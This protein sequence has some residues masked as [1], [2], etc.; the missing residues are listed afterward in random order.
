MNEVTLLRFSNEDDAALPQV[1]PGQLAQLCEHLSGIYNLAGS[2]IGVRTKLTW[3]F[4]L[5]PRKGSLEFVLIHVLDDAVV[6]NVTQI[7]RRAL[8]MSPEAAL[9]LNN[10]GLASLIYTII[11][12]GRGLVDLFVRNE[13]PVLE[14]STP[15]K[16]LKLHIVQSAL[17]K[18]EIVRHLKQLVVQAAATGAATVEIVVP[19]EPVVAILSQSIRKTPSV[20]VKVAKRT[21]TGPVPE[22]INSARPPLV[23]A[24]YGNKDATMFLAGVG[25]A[26][27]GLSVIVW[28]SAQTPPLN[29]PPVNVKATYLSAEDVLSLEPLGPLPLDFADATGVVL[30]T[31]AASYS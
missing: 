2:L 17:A 24:R 28:Q 15:E 1:S 16:A 20:L 18:P 27:N 14:D 29:K 22:Q 26:H 10:V 6:S 8:K 7:A 11:F 19:D 12:G 23:R 21:S 9:L 4:A 5:P 30:V 25:R 31:G 3:R 13:D